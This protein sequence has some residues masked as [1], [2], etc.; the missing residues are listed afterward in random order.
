MSKLL[1]LLETAKA[2][3]QDLQKDGVQGAV[4]YELLLNMGNDSLVQI[5][6]VGKPRDKG[7]VD[8]IYTMLCNF[9]TTTRQLAEGGANDRAH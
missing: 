1:E 4:T 2:A 6:I 3:K 5:V 9:A 7:V 8:E